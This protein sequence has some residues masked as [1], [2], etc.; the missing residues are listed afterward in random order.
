MTT[1][2]LELRQ[3]SRV[4]GKGD[5][6]VTA[7]RA[8]DLIVTAGQLVAVMGPSGSG[9]S[10]L[11]HLAGG[12][13]SPTDGEVLVQGM[14]LRGMSRSGLAQLRRRAIGYVFQDFNLV[15]R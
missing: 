10:T 15:P 5:A 13:D 1:A 8:V 11:L 2:V 3:V 12:L 4:H 14:S 6:A 9:K 7:L